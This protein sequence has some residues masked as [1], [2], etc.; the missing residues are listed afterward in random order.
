MT[1]LITFVKEGNASIV[2]SFDNVQSAQRFKKSIKLDPRFRGGK[3]E[4]RTAEGFRVKK[5][6]A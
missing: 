3:L 5:I 4:I 2:T 1:F 6:L